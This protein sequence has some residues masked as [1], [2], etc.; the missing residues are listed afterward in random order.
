MKYAKRQLIFFVAYLAAGALFA[1]AALLWAPAGTKEGILSGIVGGFLVTGV[2]GLILSFRLLKNPEQAERTERMKTE[3]RTQ[4][5]RMMT[6]SSVH[7]V[8]IPLVSAAAI[9]AQILGRRD[10]ALTLA[11]L[12]VVEAVLF[13]V[14]ATH[15]SKKY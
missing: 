7:T 10:I 13:V 8:T 2:G 4:Y 6:H 14:F 5:I 15:Y 1:L 9:T 3:E 12:L 11:A